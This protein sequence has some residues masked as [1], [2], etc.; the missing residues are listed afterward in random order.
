MLSGVCNGFAAYFNVD[1]TIVRILFVVA[2]LLSGGIGILVYVA[3]M[4]VIPDAN[5]SEERAAARGETF[6]ASELI[7]R[8]KKQYEEFRGKHDWRKSQEQWRGHWREQQRQWRL[9]RREWRERWRYD[10][11][12]GSPSFGN[13]DAPRPTSYATRLI[14]GFMIPVFAVL[15]AA[16]FV[17]WLIVL[18]SLASTG[19]IFGWPLPHG[20]PVWAG[21]L[22]IVLAYSAVSGPLR[23]A[24]RA[25]RHAATGHSYGWHGFGDAMFRLGFII[26]FL[27]LAYQFIPGVHN[28]VDGLPD[29]WRGVTHQATTTAMNGYSP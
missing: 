7:E 4:F 20:I 25:S 17:A 12:R 22:F 23:A 24:S 10:W 21:L 19:M 14:A 6:N 1:V 18:I 26:V 2:T 28:L 11:D 5:T 9:R 15:S 8:A 29:F 3:M 16:F 27:W 13:P